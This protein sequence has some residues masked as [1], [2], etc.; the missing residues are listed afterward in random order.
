M[1]RLLAAVFQRSGA[2]PT[3]RCRTVRRARAVGRLHARRRKVAWAYGPVT[4]YSLSLYEIDTVRSRT[5]VFVP[6]AIETIVR[7][8]STS[9]LPGSASRRVVLCLQAGEPT[10]LC[11]SHTHFPPGLP[12]LVGVQRASRG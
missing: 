10:C 6:S 5:R 7:K 2:L 4:S 9:P 8:V 1:E 12:H 3:Q 11:R